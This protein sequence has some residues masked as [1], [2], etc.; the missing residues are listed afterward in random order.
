MIIKYMLLYILINFLLYAGAL[1]KCAYH[2]FFGWLKMVKMGYGINFADH[3]NIVLDHMKQAIRD[4][5]ERVNKFGIIPFKKVIHMYK[6][7]GDSYKETINSEEYINQCHE[8]A[9]IEKMKIDS[10]FENNK[11]NYLE[12]YNAVDDALFKPLDEKS[13]MGKLDDDSPVYLISG[14]YNL[15]ELDYISFVTN[16]KKT[17]GTINGEWKCILDAIDL[18]EIK[19]TFPTFQEKTV[20]YSNTTRK[21][22]IIAMHKPE[23]KNLSYAL[24]SIAYNKFMT[25]EPVDIEFR[26]IED[27]PVKLTK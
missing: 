3:Y 13:I 7:L 11:N 15:D 22:K 9:D 20:D 2:V 5:K 8:L 18:E 6:I 16:L 14:E 1:G 27:Q 25:K 4:N 26:E 10:A 19:E 23:Y 12:L 24:S 17:F 21:F